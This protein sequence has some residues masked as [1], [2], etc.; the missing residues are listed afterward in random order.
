MIISGWLLTACVEEPEGPE[1]Q[2]IE[3]NQISKVRDWFEE[4]KSKLKLPEKGSNFRTDSQE[5]ILPFFEK[6]PD[7]D[8]FHHYFF[9][10]GREV[11]E[12]NLKKE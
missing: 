3:T 11:F 10:D 5:L 8:K 6:E 7:W 1:I 4:N 12:V 2:T 9:E